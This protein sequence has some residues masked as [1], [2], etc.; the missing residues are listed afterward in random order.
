MIVAGK[1]QRIDAVAA[2][3]AQEGGVGDDQRVVAFAAAQHVGAAVADEDVVAEPADHVVRPAIADQ[4]CRP[5]RC[6][7][8]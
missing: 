2:G 6:P 1:R 4:R 5:R 8:A 3:D 7:D